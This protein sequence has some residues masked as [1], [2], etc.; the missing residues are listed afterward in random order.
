MGIGIQMLHVQMDIINVA[1]AHLKINATED[2]FAVISSITAASL[3]YISLTSK[4][5]DFYF[6]KCWES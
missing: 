4:T 6:K 1:I 2:Y 5:V 3:T